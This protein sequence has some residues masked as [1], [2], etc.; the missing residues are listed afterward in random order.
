MHVNIE[1][2]ILYLGTPVVLI[3]STNQDNSFNLAPMSSA[4][5]LGWRCLLGMGTKSQTVQNLLR[6]GECVLNLPSV[7]SVA[8][9]DRLALTTGANPVP[10]YKAGRGYRHEKDKFAVS[11]FT[12]M[13]SFTVRPPGIL[14]C[15]VQMEAVLAAVHPVADDDPTQ[16]GGIG[17][18][19]VRIQRVW[20]EEGLLNPDKPDHIDPDLWRPLIMSFQKF[21]GLGRDQVHG[22]TLSQIPEIRYRSPD[23]AR[24]QQ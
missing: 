19:E 18:F 2:P 21:Y 4:F 6:T 14:E 1:P 17:C 12:P 24:S 5:W 23:V 10:D 15:P 8:A 13:P 11:G 3:S 9:V 7:D 16:K 22:S 20:V